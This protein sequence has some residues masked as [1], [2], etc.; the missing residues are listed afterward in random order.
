MA[1]RSSTTYSSDVGYGCFDRTVT[2]TG[3]LTAFAVL[4]GHQAIASFR[5]TGTTTGPLWV[6]SVDL[7][8]PPRT[9][10]A[11]P[12][13]MQVDWF[14]VGPG[15]DPTNPVDDRLVCFSAVGCSPFGGPPVS[16]EYSAP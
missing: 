9:T 14:T 2:M 6:Q 10:N 7:C 8:G 1:Q 3:R 4:A 12:F 15:T 11:V 16:D 5:M 13:D